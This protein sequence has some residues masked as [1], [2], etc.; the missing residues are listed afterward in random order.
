[1]KYFP[2]PKEFFFFGKGSYYSIIFSNELNSNGNP[3][4]ELY[5][6]SKARVLHFFKV[7]LQFNEIFL[8]F[9]YHFPCVYRFFLLKLRWILLILA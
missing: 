3:N 9:F 7:V 4:K 5:N 6:Q 2:L 8:L 1:M